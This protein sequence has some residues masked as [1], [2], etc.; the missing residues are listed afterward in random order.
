MTK[1]LD[2]NMRFTLP[3]NTEL[4]LFQTVG[5]VNTFFL[6]TPQDYSRIP[7]RPMMDHFV[8]EI[9]R[10]RVAPKE[11]EILS[12]Q[13][14]MMKVFFEIN[15]WRMVRDNDKIDTLLAEIDKLASM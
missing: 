8:S 14:E 2:M 6:I 4:P 1:I 9:Y 3:D 11:K 7:N 13:R 5:E 15:I 10:K 12:P